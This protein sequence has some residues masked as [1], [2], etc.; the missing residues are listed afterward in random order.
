MLLG[1]A[2]NSIPTTEEDV[3]GVVSNIRYVKDPR[4]DLC[5]AVISSA[6]ATGSGLSTSMSLANVPCE[7]V[8]E[9]LV[10]NTLQ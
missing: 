1:C 3:V 9:L 7:K 4:T 10:K 5:F 6:S 8:Q 2:P